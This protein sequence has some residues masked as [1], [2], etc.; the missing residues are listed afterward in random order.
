MNS[1]KLSTLLAQDADPL[2][3]L[4]NAL[5]CQI[6]KD[7]FDAPVTL[8]CGHCWCSKC[9]RSFMVAQ[10]GRGQCP[11]CRRDMTE[12]HL[13]PSSA[14]EDAVTAWKRARDCILGLAHGKS[15]ESADGPVK[16]KR[17]LSSSPPV[18]GP[19]RTPS[20]ES[21]ETPSEP[22]EMKPDT[23][24]QCPL[25]SCKMRYKELNAHMDKNCAPPVSTSDKSQ[26]TQW[27]DIMGSKSKGKAKVDQDPLPKVAYD[28]LKEKQLRDKLTEH[29][30]STSGTHAQMVARHQQWTLLWNANLDKSP[31]NRQSTTE[32]RKEMR[33]WED[34]QKNKKK[35]PEVD[36]KS[37][38]VTYP[39]LLFSVYLTILD[40]AEGP[41]CSASGSS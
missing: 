4:D 14:I 16:K 2:S 27:S 19:S 3:A 36:S 9:I 28:T 13:R 29:G 15:Q 25:C 20:I 17:K 33:R 38:L 40:Y 22:A 7:F 41:V 5:R 37:H 11:T 35:R 18:S 34:E 31:A 12:S 23:V 24:V 26:K 30:L 39:L 21:R 6:C 32:L 1:N 10:T 8:A